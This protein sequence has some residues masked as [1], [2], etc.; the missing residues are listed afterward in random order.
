[1]PCVSR[2]VSNGPY[3]TSR[4]SHV[5]SPSVSCRNQMFGML[6]QMTP[7][8]Y[9]MSPIG[10]LSLSAKTVTTSALPS[11]SVSSRMRIVS[12]GVTSAAAAKGYSS[13]LLTHNRPLPSKARFMGFAMS[14]SE[15]TS[16]TRKPSGTTNDFCSS[17]GL[18]AS[19]VRTPNANGSSAGG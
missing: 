17:S 8:P 13:E 9:G 4:S 18:T 15:A 12:R 14:G 7:S 19:V 2:V 1:M 6:K 16:S 3:S 10:M 5:P 11:P